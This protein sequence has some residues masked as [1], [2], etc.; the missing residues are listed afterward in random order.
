MKHVS[1]VTVVMSFVLAALATPE[2]HSQAD[3]VIE[4]ISGPQI[5]NASQLNRISSVTKNIGSAPAGASTTAIV[6]ARRGPVSGTD[7]MLGFDSIKALA[8]NESVTITRNYFVPNCM[9]VSWIPCVI[10]A[11][12]DIGRTVTERD[13]TNNTRVFPI[14][15]G[16]NYSYDPLTYFPR[17]GSSAISAEGAATFDMKTGGSARMCIMTNRLCYPCRYLCV[18]SGRRSFAFDSLSQ[19]SLT[20][21]NNAMFPAWF[22]SVVDQS[23]HPE[24][25]VPKLSGVVPFTAYVHVA[26]WDTFA[27]QFSGFA[28]PLRMDF[29]S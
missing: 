15:H 14:R 24:L 26:L 19:F 9:D 23:Q 3:L 17:W 21:L 7:L 29:K 2:V 10:G 6:A 1:H 25:H 4:S 27:G 18:W 12:C 22:G 20:F 13:E 8:P 5:L 28:A 11:I 16:A